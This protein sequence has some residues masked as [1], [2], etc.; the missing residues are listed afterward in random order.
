MI[1]QGRVGPGWTTKLLT[2]RGTYIVL[3]VANGDGGLR[4]PGPVLT[5]RALGSPGAPEFTASLGEADFTTLR[6]PGGLRAIP[7]VT[8]GTYTTPA[9][10]PGR[11]GEA[12]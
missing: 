9:P 5:L 12:G 6:P 2:R 11:A 3:A 10:L 4:D 7:A 1:S 8:R